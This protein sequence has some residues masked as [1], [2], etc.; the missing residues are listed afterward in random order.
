M[1]KIGGLIIIFILALM[2]AGFFYA[3]ILYP[4]KAEAVSPGGVIINEIQVYPIGKR[5]IEIY[6]MNNFSVDL[7]GWSVKKK[8]SGG[9]EDSLLASSRFKGKFILAKSYLLLTS[10]EGYISDAVSDI[11]WAKSNTIAKDNTVIIYDNSQNVIDKVGFGLSTDC[12]GNEGNCALNP[13]ENFSIQRNFFID[14]NNNLADFFIQENPNP[15]NSSSTVATAPPADEQLIIPVEP[16][17]APSETATSTNMA[18]DMPAPPPPEQKINFGDVVI[19]ELVSDP[20]DNEVEFIELYNKTNKKIDLTGWR[21]EDGSKAKTNLT[22]SLVKYK[23]IEKPSGSL[24]NA[25]DLVV[26]Y[27]ASE[28]IIDQVAYGDWNDGNAK[29]N[30][31]VAHDPVS[32][33]RKYDGYNTYDNF[34][35]FAITLKPTKGASNIIEVEAED[36]VGQAAKADFDFSNDIFI[37]EILPNPLGDDTKAEF[38][39]IYN[40]GRREVNLTGWSISNEDNKKKYLENMATS[41]IIKAGEYLT[42]FR[43]RTKIVLHNDQGEVKLFEPLADK[44][45]TT[46]DYKNV[47]EGLSYNL[48]DYNIKS[49][50]VWSETITPGAMNA[51]KTINQ[52]P[53]VEFSFKSPALVNAPV[54][55]DSSDTADQDDD[56]LKFSWDFGDGFKNSLA[57]PEH[58]YLKIGIY[59]VKLEVSDV[60]ATSTKEKSVKVVSNVS[61]IKNV[62]DSR[63]RENDKIEEISRNDNIIINE[64]F[65]NPSGADTGQEWLELKN[66]GV[67]E[68]NLLN[69]RVEN[70]NGKYEFK[71]EELI[72]A[73]A[74]YVLD[75]AK[76]KLAFKN[77]ADVVILYNNLDELADQVDYA[78]AVQGEIYARGANNKWF[79]TTKATPGEENII[80]LAA[81]EASIKYKAA[82]ISGNADEHAETTLEKVRQM[83]IGS[84]VKVKGTVA[85][86][87]GILGVQIFYIVGSPGIQIYNYKKDFPAL[88]VGDYIEVMGELAQTQGELRIKTKDKSNISFLEHKDAPAALAIKAEEISEENIGQLLTITGEITDKK[89]TSLYIDDGSDEMFVYIK[90]NT[91]IDTKSLTAGQKVSVTGILSKTQ[92]GFRLLPRYQSDIAVIESAEGLKPQVFGEVASAEE[93]DLAER[94]KKLE[95]F[96]YLL[97]IAGG[98]IILL[99]GLF[100]KMKRKS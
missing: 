28:R 81:S 44:P 7:T 49:Q 97:I 99:T 80:S 6:N 75:N 88:K 64:I 22:G 53:E 37:S 33:V 11:M 43:P 42:F 96:K 26:L 67:T 77:T 62:L 31:P 19:N 69:W 17:P 65:P 15:Q 57:S 40:A 71:S 10:E 4:N 29:D 13:G 76:S 55:F 50:W 94:D 91:G 35:D 66:Q 73:G 48:T 86:P 60:Q 93:W 25:G 79:W 16:N 24:N 52:P 74:F 3:Q 84:L 87:P 27:D 9:K 20:A 82:S 41:T 100:I 98:V 2:S 30:A 5:F 51:L 83:E 90:Q 21:L 23:V 8:T 56:K 47:K 39:E 95:L 78:N 1:K 85:A 61:E 12:E 70:S 68:I 89:S 72:K 58:T 46:V 63:L 32:L 36:E 38:I 18:E 54:I 92:T 45:I 34:N 14:T 59:K